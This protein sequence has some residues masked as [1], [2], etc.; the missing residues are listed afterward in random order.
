MPL[1]AFLGGIVGEAFGLVAV[2]VVF[3]VL[4]AL[5]VFGR[6]VVTDEAIRA[7]E[8]S[9]PPAD[10]SAPPAAGSAPPTDAAEPSG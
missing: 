2:F 9:A 7:A 6:L 8:A 4:Q 1:G 5:L 10:G 3:G